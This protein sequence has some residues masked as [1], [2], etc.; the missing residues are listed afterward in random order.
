[1]YG[2]TSVRWIVH[3]LKLNRTT[4]TSL[5]VVPPIYNLVYC[6]HQSPTTTLNLH[7]DVYCLM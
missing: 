5:A 1:M 3:M 4:N 6:S 2:S 7:S